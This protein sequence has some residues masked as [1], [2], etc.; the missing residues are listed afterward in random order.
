MNTNAVFYKSIL[1][2]EFAKRTE[3]NPRYSL[4]AMAKLQ[5]L[6]RLYPKNGQP[7]VYSVIHD[8]RF[9]I[10]NSKP[11]YE[12]KTEVDASVETP[13]GSICFSVF[14]LTKD[15]VLPSGEKR[16][17]LT[18]D[19][20]N[21]T[22]AALGFHEVSHKLNFNEQEAQLVQAD[23]LA[24]LTNE[25]VVKGLAAVKYFN[26]LLGA[27]DAK[28]VDVEAEIRGGL[29]QSSICVVLGEVQMRVQSLSENLSE[30]PLVKDIQIL[31]AKEQ[32]VLGAVIGSKAAYATLYCGTDVPGMKGMM[33]KIFKGQ[34]SVPLLDL[35]HNETGKPLTSV[36]TQLLSKY[37]VY[38]TATGGIPAVQQEMVDL[39]GALAQIRNEMQTRWNIK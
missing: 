4:R 27:A 2:E 14:R 7:T 19:D 9:S 3:K 38:N 1:E 18:I 5:L 25:T 36:Y 35:I 17:H 24:N 33:D 31:T 20:M 26:F 16:S 30:N 32:L 28:V 23:A 12:G 34:P 39:E 11:C 29:P 6:K 15:V 13:D 10:E 37:Q 8:A 21:V 22:I